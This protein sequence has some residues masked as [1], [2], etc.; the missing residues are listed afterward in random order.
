MFFLNYALKCHIQHSHTL[1]LF[2]LIHFMYL[3]PFPVHAI[4][5]KSCSS[6]CTTR[7]TKPINT[8]HKI[9]PSACL[10][11]TACACLCPKEELTFNTLGQPNSL[12]C[13]VVPAEESFG[14]DQVE[15]LR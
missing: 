4:S 1:V 2:L 10:V 11:Y 15:L 8:V 5:T 6:G 13:I 3:P 7:A 12:S 14:T 9:D